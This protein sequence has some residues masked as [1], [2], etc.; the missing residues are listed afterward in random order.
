V[1]YGQGRIRAY[2]P[3]KWAVP[4]NGKRAPLEGIPP[5]KVLIAIEPAFPEDYVM[6]VD[7][8]LNYKGDDEDV[9][10]CK[11]YIVA[12]FEDHID[13]LAKILACAKRGIDSKVIGM[14]LE[15]AN[16]GD[17]LGVLLGHYDI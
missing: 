13:A 9:I 14:A 1:A 5:G 3:V 11:N 2:Q 7:S 4:K 15:P 16:P 8:F 12:N 6:N 10:E 17:E